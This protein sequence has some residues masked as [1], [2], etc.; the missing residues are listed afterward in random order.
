MWRVGLC[1]A[2]IACHGQEA[3]K[4]AAIEEHV[5]AAADAPRLDAGYCTTQH[6]CE[7]AQL[8]LCVMCCH[9]DICGRDAW[10]HVGACTS[11][12]TPGSECN[13]VL[14]APNEPCYNRNGVLGTCVYTTVSFM[15]PDMYWVCQ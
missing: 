10:L 3:P 6:D 4:D 9:F 7:A 12:V 1:A 11:S 5:D 13:V 14:C 15:N 2:L 8:P